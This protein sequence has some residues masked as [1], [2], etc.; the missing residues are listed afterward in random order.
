MV[1]II[2]RTRIENLRPKLGREVITHDELRR[3]FI[4]EVLMPYLRQETGLLA[5]IK[6]ERKIRGG[7]Y[8]SR[9]GGLYFEFKKPGEGIEE[10][11]EK[12]QE[13][14]IPEERKKSEK[15]DFFITDGYEA[16][17]V[18]F[19]GK[20]I[21]RGRADELGG[22][23]SELLDIHYRGVIEPEDILDALGP[24]SSLYLDHTRLLWS[25]ITEHSE[26]PTVKQ[27][28]EMWKRIYAE[29]ANLSGDAKR[30]V[31][32]QAK[33]LN[34]SL[35]NTEE[36]RKFLFITQ[37]YFSVLMKL[38]IGKVSGLVRGEDVSK[39][40]QRRD[41]PVESY[42][43]IRDSFLIKGVAEHDLFDWFIYPARKS[44][45]TSD[46]ISDALLKLASTVDV[47][48]YSS[49]KT[50]L[51]RDIYQR[52]FE[53]EM[54]IAMG[55]F[56]TNEKLVDEVLDSVVYGGK[57]ILDKTLLDPTCGSGTFLIKAIER[58]RKVAE[59]KGLDGS[60]ILERITEQINGFDLHPF[61]VTMA[62]T[63]YLIA[64]SGLLEDQTPAFIKKLEIPVYWTDSLT[65]FSNESVTNELTVRAMPFEEELFLP[66]P[67]EVDL[68]TVFEK[69]EEALSG[70]RWKEERFLDEFD[71]EI[72]GKF[73]KTLSDLYYFFEKK[74]N[75]MWLPTLR[76]TLKVLELRKECDY[77]VGNPPW[78]RKR[79]VDA[80]LRERLSESFDFYKEM[81]NPP[82]KKYRY[83]RGSMDYSVAF[84]ESGLGY[85]RKKGKLGFVITSN[86]IRSLYAGNFRKK[87]TKDCRIIEIK[88][89]AFSKENL[90]EGAQNAPLILSFEKDIPEEN[91]V[92]VSIV[93][94][95]G[96]WKRWKINQEELPLLENDSRSPWILIPPKG[97][98][99]VKKMIKGDKMLGNLYQTNM[100]VKTA[101]NSIFWIDK[102]KKTDRWPEI[103]FVE[104]TGGR[105]VESQKIRIETEVI[106]PLLRGR[107]IDD[108][109]FNVENYILWTHSDETGEVRN[110]LP[111]RVKSYFM[112]DEIQKKLK[113]RSDYSEE[114]PVWKIFRSSKKKLTNKVA[115][116]SV[117]KTIEAVFVPSKYRDEKLSERKLIASTSVYFISG[118]REDISYSLAALLNSSPVRAYV[119]SYVTKTGGLYCTHKAYHLGL[120][121]LPQKVKEGKSELLSLSKKLHEIEGKDEKLLRE[122]DERVA[123]LYGLTEDELKTMKD[124]LGFFVN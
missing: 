109:N 29:A 110:N 85:L 67:K 103:A 57:E 89:Y 111:P 9:I 26:N 35:Q 76:N 104:T 5:D 51:L 50:D 7:Y 70:I 41:S 19:E 55:E 52:S 25:I 84:V 17:H 122:L 43:I 108:W 118:A 80:S 66:N 97:V 6:M 87:L 44:K 31:K 77:L 73:E 117:A 56:Y 40:L 116:Q 15:I 115:F 59:R 107:N 38:M 33:D 36:I 45:E 24:D 10:G 28:Y 102:L 23:L 72:R 65:T 90:F 49:V 88:D 69:L 83:F 58:F 114:D 93:N 21:E 47:I 3:A 22:R 91:E 63:N 75:S 14:Y 64:I 18:N 32:K 60:E 105:G 123:E 79:N 11:I 1:R 37:T 113:K 20:V 34:L 101:A 13:K 39:W 46:K 94:R 2:I 112:E 68:K 100:G 53:K 27:S 119:A 98:A 4:D 30:A 48:D 86:V 71:Q 95:S 120:V 96:R 8:D 81:W 82:L 106:R 74:E 78:V 92:R 12:A 54:R 42:R 62:R 121:P 61:A 16:A 99:A 124:F